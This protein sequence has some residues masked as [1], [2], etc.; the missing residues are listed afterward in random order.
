MKFKP[1]FIERYSQLTNWDQ[2]REYS[3]SFLRRSIRINT[4]LASIA[5][6]K[7]S[8]QE[9]GWQLDPIPWCKEG[10]WIFHPDRRDVG[11]LFE[12]HLGQIYVQEAASMIPPLVLNPKPGE[13]VLDMC[14]APGSKTTQMAV[15][16]KNKGLI[17]AN[18][19]KGARLQSLGINLQRSGLTNTIVSLMSGKRFHEFEFD[20]ILVDAPCSGTGTIRKSLKTISIWNPGMISKLARQQKELIVSAFENLKSGGEMV[21]STCSVEPEENEGVVDYLLEKFDNAEVVKVKLPG[22]KLA[23]SVMEFKG[24]KYNSAVKDVM[25][26]WPQD[27]DT[28]GFFVCKIRKN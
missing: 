22:L 5:E 26:I 15:M 17:V 2:F 10:F 13:I 19:Y 25:R 27:N 4:N 11:N 14:A 21:Y 24:K 8:I 12:H 7:K 23:K 18:D 6:V 16:M 9:K 1:L 20:K 3:L 28:E